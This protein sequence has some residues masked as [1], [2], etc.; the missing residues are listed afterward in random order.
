MKRVKVP[1]L[2]GSKVKTTHLRGGRRTVKPTGAN[3]VEVQVPRAAG[4]NE[5]RTTQL[6][7]WTNA[8][9]PAG[10]NAARTTQPK[11]F[12]G[13]KLLFQ[14]LCL[15]YYDEAGNLMTGLKVALLVLMVAPAAIVWNL[16]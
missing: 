13:A 4:T 8:V 12:H 1:R 3:E 9:K 16:C 5:V 7:G 10:T 14:N 6:A 15:R 11:N 2:A